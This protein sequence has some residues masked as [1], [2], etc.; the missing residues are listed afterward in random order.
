MKFKIISIIFFVSIVFSFCKNSPSF[1]EK[2]FH[3]WGNN[4]QCKTTIEKACVASGVS[5]AKWD[6]D[7]KLLKLKIDT[8]I[9]SYSDVLKQVATAGY[10]NE[11]FFGNDYAY[12][13][14]PEAC[15]YERRVD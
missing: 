1:A 8:T 7:S 5:D 12:S 15:Q 14:L 4:E 11:V 2:S 9:I 10:D 3:V 13:K 6:M